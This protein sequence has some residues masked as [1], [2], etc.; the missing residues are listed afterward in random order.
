MILVTGGT[1]LLGSHLLHRLVSDGM[2][3][4][5]I[6]RKSSDTEFTRK[7]FS[8][9]AKD[10][11]ELFSKIQW[12]DGDITDVYSLED[13]FEEIDFVYHCAAIVSFNAA[14]KIEMVKTNSIG[15]ANIINLCLEKKIKKLCHVS[16]I[17]AL[18]RSTN[19]SMISES[20]GWVTSKQN[21]FYA[22]SKYNA[23]RE[24]WRG[25]NEGLNAVI[26]NPSI[27]LGPGDWKND[28]SKIFTLVNNGLKFY[29]NG[30]N[31]YV[32]VIDVVNSMVLLMNND[33]SAERFII[34]SENYSYR[35]LLNAIAKNLNKPLPKYHAN[36]F[37]SELAW[38][39]E[40]TRSVLTNSNPLITKQ[41][42]KTAA[43]K[44]F[45]NNEKFRQKYNYKYLSVDESVKRIC[46][47][48][49]KQKSH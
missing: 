32:D 27:I 7:V 15:T 13:A 9:Y 49:I 25:I 37:I 24:V 20:T 35:D 45:Y 31:A 8:Y 40:K 17:A 10:Y 28:S 16:S 47:I 22:I 18:G 3:V 23:E 44:S 41:I 12:V 46:E 33:V 1:G 48:L 34:A 30:V 38:R 21:S 14:D 26:I 19:S 2:T 43:N 4:R 29:T 36:S 11:N 6:K 39:L 42:V 5:A